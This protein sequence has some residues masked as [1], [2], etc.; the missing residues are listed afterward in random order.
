MFEPN[1]TVPGVFGKVS[2]ATGK[3]YEFVCDVTE[4][5][6]SL[7]FNVCVRNLIIA[8][9]SGHVHFET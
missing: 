3:P 5:T 7:Y 2:Q 9:N 6:P 1:N 8:A 4:D